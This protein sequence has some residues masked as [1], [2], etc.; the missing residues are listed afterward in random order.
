MQKNFLKTTLL[1]IIARKRMVSIEAN[2][3]SFSNR[4]QEDSVIFQEMLNCLED[5][6]ES[7]K[8]ILSGAGN[9]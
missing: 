2:D 6:D 5:F 4:F 9:S 1:I 3:I 8:V 7:E